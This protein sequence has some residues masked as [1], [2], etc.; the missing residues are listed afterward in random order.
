LGIQRTD[1]QT[2]TYVC[3]GV[4]RENYLAELGAG[5]RITFDMMLL[6]ML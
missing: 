3:V 1:K 2:A 5:G 6:N 4:L